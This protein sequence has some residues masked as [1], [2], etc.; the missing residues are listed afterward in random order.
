[1]AKILLETGKGPLPILTAYPVIIVGANVDGKPDFTTAAWTG[2][3]CSVPPAISVALQHHRY[4]LKG[5]RQN[6]A[7]SVNIPSTD[8]VKETDYC[9]LVSGSKTD[10]AKDCHFHVFY[11][12]NETVP[13]I[14]QCVINHVCEVVQILNLGSHELVIGRIIESHASEECLTDGRP[15]P[16]KTKPFMFLGGEYFALG[17]SVGKCFETG[18]SINPK[19]KIDMPG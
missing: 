13:L 12:K 19:I 14:E 1:M 7:F 18:K 2:V 9:G 5:I 11:G 6:M 10:K 4:V 15:D 16:E 3:A 17:K 8:V